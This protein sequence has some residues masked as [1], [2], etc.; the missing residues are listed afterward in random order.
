MF[1]TAGIASII[2]VI[3]IGSIYVVRLNQ[4]S[5]STYPIDNDS[6]LNDTQKILESLR[7]IEESLGRIEPKPS[8]SDPQAYQLWIV[9][10]GISTVF[11]A[12]SVE[13]LWAKAALVVFGLVLI[14]AS[15]WLS[16]RTPR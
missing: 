9:A 1:A 2:L 5:V 6:T 12:L 16:R 8:N 4:S 3:V 15:T 11:G 7:L 13:V 10:I 14:V